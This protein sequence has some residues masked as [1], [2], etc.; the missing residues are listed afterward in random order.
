MRYDVV[1]HFRQESKELKQLIP[2][3]NNKQRASKSFFFLSRK[4]VKSQFGVFCVRVSANSN[5]FCER[6]VGFKTTKT[7][8][9]IEDLNV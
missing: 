2:L 7:E 6:G 9:K 3:S 5:S 4:N 1:R 8:Q